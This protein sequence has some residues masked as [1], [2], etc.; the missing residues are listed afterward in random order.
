MVNVQPQVDTGMVA[1]E[2]CL[3]HIPKSVA[4][5]EEGREHVYYFCGPRCYEKW[6]TVPGIREVTITA[7]GLDVDFETAQGLAKTAAYR[8][9]KDEEAKLIAWFDR[10]RAKGYPEV[11]ES[12]KKPAWLTYAKSH[13]GKIIIDVNHGLYMFVFSTAV[14]RNT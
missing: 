11:S 4:E 8:C 13:E 1:C 5:S 14:E 10:A 12:Q 3:K 9:T 6:E 7:S 2:V